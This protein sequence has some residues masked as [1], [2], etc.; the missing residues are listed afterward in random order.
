[1]E[2]NLY[3]KPKTYVVVIGIENIMAGDVITP[4]SDPDAP[5]GVNSY[6]MDVE[7]NIPTTTGTSLWDE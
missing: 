5:P 4:E 3:I 6:N 2:K 7:E 1:M